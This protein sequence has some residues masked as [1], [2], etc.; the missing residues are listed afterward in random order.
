MKTFS[1]QATKFTLVGM[2]NFGLTFIVFTTMLKALHMNYLLS[3]WAAWVIGIL[4][5]YVLNHSWVFQPSERLRF[6]A[7]FLKYLFSSC[8]SVSINMLVLAYI[9]ESRHY[10]AFYVQLF[11]IPMIVIINFL[12]AKYWSLRDTGSPRTKGQY[13][14]DVP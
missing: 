7:R 1:I 8:L 2:A 5:S 12:T 6:K 13:S 9:V 11:L 10:D 14:E 3:L 4:F